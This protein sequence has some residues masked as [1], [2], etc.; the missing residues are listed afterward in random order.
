M[1]TS[2]RLAAANRGP[3]LLGREKSLFALARQEVAQ[4]LQPEKYHD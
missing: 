4:Q 2:W 1:S 3:D